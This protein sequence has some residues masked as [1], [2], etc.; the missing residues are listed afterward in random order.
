MQSYPAEKIVEITLFRRSEAMDGAPG[1]I[2]KLEAEDVARRI[3]IS[4]PCHSVLLCW[5]SLRWSAQR[6]GSCGKLRT[7]A[8]WALPLR[9]HCLAASCALR[10]WMATFPGFRIYLS[11][12]MCLARVIRPEVAKIG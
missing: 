12:G 11:P 1:R 5:A 7:S 8:A 2:V 4:R 10:E 3:C 9:C 6:V